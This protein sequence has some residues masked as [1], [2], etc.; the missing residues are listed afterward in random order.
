MIVNF[1]QPQPNT[2]K[3]LVLILNQPS[4]TF[5]LK[6][7]HVYSFLKNFS[8]RRLSYY[9]LTEFISGL[10]DRTH[11]YRKLLPQR[12]SKWV[13]STILFLKGS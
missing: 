4:T 6:Q 12:N 11:L 2:V 8:F 1:I 5:R 7:N 3:S 13:K 9:K 10:T